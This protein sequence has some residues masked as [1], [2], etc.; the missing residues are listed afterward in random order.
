MLGIV[1]VPAIVPGC[2]DVG[3]VATCGSVNAV[4]VS[5]FVLVIAVVDGGSGSPGAVIVDV[6]ADDD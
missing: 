3:A 1:S 4:V 6:T 2:V 5:R